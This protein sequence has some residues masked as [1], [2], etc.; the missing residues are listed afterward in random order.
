M[1]CTFHEIYPDEQINKTDRGT[2]NV[3]GRGGGRQSVYRGLVARP[4]GKR[5][6]ARPR[7]GRC[8]NIK[9]ATN[10]SYGKH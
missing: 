1:L 4:D 9:M 2:G 6:L 3:L 10:K 7:Q 8:N 5:S